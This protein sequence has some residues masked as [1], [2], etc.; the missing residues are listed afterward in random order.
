MKRILTVFLTSMLL[1]ILTLLS[2]SAEEGESQTSTPIPVSLTV[3]TPPERVKYAAFESFSTEG[4]TVRVDYLSGESEILSAERLTVEYLT[5][6]DRLRYGDCGVYISYLDFRLLLPLEVKKREYDIT[7]LSLTAEKRK[8]SGEWQSL[9]YSGELPVGLDGIALS[10]EVV[11]GGCDV[12]VYSVSL[13]FSTESRD[14]RAPEPQNARLEIEPYTLV[15]EWG[16]TDFTYDGTPKLPSATAKNERGETLTLSVMG[17]GIYASDS[18]VAHAIAPSDNYVLSGALIAY[19]IKK[20]DY[21]T[22]GVF[23]TQ[24]SFVYD[25]GAKSVTLTALPDGVTLI[26]YR[27]A[28]AVGAGKYTAEAIVGY[29]TRNYNPPKIPIITW[30]ISKA[31]YDMSGVFWTGE[32]TVYSGEEQRITLG[33]LPLGVTVREYIGGV[34]VGAGRYPVS[35]VF[36]YDEDNYTPPTISETALVIAKR[37]VRIPSRIS[38]VYD[39]N[40]REIDIS[41]EEYYQKN[42]F[43]TE[44]LGTHGLELVLYDP[45]NY[46][47]EDGS[48]STRVEVTVTL[49][50]A[51]FIMVG[52]TSAL[53]CVLVVVAVIFVVR[54]QRLRRLLAAIR[55]K[56]TLGEEILLPPPRNS[57]GPLALLSV[58]V[59]RADELISDS[60]AKNL[61]TKKEEPIYT[62]GKR[63]NIINV[64]TLSCEFSDGDRIDVNV[65]KE[66]GLVPEDTAYIKVLARGVINKP[67]FVYANDF[68]LAAVKMIALTGGEAIRVV[69]IRKKE[70]KKK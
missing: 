66:K 8:Y 54:R 32:R 33:G 70:N 31:T 43:Y 49:P 14:Y 41:A 67:L 29:D 20:A 68:S 15:L 61:I 30:E 39:G 47:F 18:Y 35:V 22:S 58:G 63:K 2:A 48:S 69:T 21:D 42:S 65:L 45:D 57:E 40:R 56:A 1:F 4:L 51:A 26:G 24:S 23:W 55:C 59:E 28:S 17:E 36:D 5:D 52:A 62:S 34:G 10:A 50:R 38:L 19:R 13:V 7:A 9:S 25:G 37:T 27:G 53:M 3:V 11:G 64:D 46:A 16:N 44:M 60:L 12:G 6:A